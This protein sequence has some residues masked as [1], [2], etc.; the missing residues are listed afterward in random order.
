MKLDQDPFPANVN[1]VELEGKKVLIR[2]SQAESTKCK[3][4]VIGTAKKSRTFKPR[5]PEVGH[6][7]TN[8][9]RQ[10]P[11]CPKACFDIVLAKYKDGQAGVRKHEEK[12]VKDSRPPHSV[13]SSSS[14]A[15]AN[16]NRSRT[17]PHPH[18]REEEH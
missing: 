7:K 1:T 3:N 2:P 5:S 18:P 14:C 15:P 12:H 16:G 10:S 6:W 4:V 8:E 9:R 17:P 13:G 11:P